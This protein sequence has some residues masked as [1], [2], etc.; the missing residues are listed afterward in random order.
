M[1][2]EASKGAGSIAWPGFERVGLNPSGGSASL[3][4]HIQATLGANGARGQAPVFRNVGRA[5]EAYKG[6]IVLVLLIY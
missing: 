5:G 4:Y 1:G 6:D 2:V 3:H